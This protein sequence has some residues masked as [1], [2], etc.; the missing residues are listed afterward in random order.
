[1]TYKFNGPSASGTGLYFQSGNEDLPMDKLQSF[2]PCRGVGAGT[3]P[4]LIGNAPL[5]ATA[6]GWAASNP[7]GGSLGSA[8]FATSGKYLETTGDGLLQDPITRNKKW[9]CG[10]WFYPDTASQVDAL[11]STS[12]WLGPITW[13]TSTGI[14]T[15]A[16]SADFVTY[17]GSGWNTAVNAGTW[18]VD[19][20]NFMLFGHDGGSGSGT[21]FASLNGAAA[22]TQGGQTIQAGGATNQVRMGGGGLWDPGSQGFDGMIC[23]VSFW[24][25]V[26][27]NATSDEIAALYNGGNGNTLIGG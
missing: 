9:W 6:V 16:G 7:G 21:S 22:V 18:V 12:N 14:G 5:S 4:D 15:S 25:D 23:D 8:K 2:W 3:S 17:G 20:W 13:Y 19:T 26:A 24:V 27:A 11:V 10:F 1:M